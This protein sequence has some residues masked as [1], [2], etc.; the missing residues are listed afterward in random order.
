MAPERGGPAQQQPPPGTPPRPGSAGHYQEPS[1]QRA[2]QP[3]A[4][5]YPPPGTAGGQPMRPGSGPA[6]PRGGHGGLPSRAV[7]VSDDP[8][9][10]VDVPP[11]MRR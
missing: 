6:G 1:A 8:D 2:Q 5:G 10:E 3:P 11:F 7:P 9:D 4:S